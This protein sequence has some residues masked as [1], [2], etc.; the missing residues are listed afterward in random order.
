MPEALADELTPLI[1][2]RLAIR[3]AAFLS[4]G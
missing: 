3:A 2:D 1:E 4:L